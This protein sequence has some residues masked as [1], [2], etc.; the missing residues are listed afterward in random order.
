MAAEVKA[1]ARC[2][3]AD[4]TGLKSFMAAT[5]NCIAGILAY[6]GTEPIKA[7]EK[8]WAIPVSMLLA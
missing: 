3:S 5:P 7:G 4:L 6:N 1:A 8:I 2:D